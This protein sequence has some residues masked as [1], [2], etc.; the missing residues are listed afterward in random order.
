MRVW[1]S[2]AGETLAWGTGVCAL[3]VAATLNGYTNRDVTVHL[4]G[5]GLKVKRNEEDNHVY[6]TGPAV[7]VFEGKI[8][9]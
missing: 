1:E 6:M 4:L 8:E 3:V 2:K 5:G 9:W 7:A